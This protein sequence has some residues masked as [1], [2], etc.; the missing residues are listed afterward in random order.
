MSLLTM[1]EVTANYV[2]AGADKIK[3]P[4]WKMLV[5]GILAGIIIG[6][7]STVSNTSAH[8]LVNG[9]MVRLVTGLTFAFGLGMVVQVGAELFTGN[10][11]LIIPVLE[12][13][14]S[15]RGMLKNWFFVYIGNF[16]GALMVAAACALFGQLTISNEGLAIY[17]MKAAAAKNTLPFA[18]G[19]VFGFLC[20]FLVCLGIFLALSAQDLAGR[21]IGAFMPVA[22]FVTNGFE[23][24]IANM[25]YVPAGLLAMHIP[26]YATKAAEA[27]VNI[28]ALTWGKFITGNLLPVTLGNI[29]GGAAF[30][31]IMWACNLPHTKGGKG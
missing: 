18:S 19:L 30:A 3:L 13:Q 28:G 1:Q 9:G 8:A 20:N 10:S 24:S 4:I 25:Y 6:M 2:K 27:G 16:A 31:L 22:Y 12:K 15:L 11:L 29:L 23:H 14:G 7:S 26:S 17:T 5:L 21:V